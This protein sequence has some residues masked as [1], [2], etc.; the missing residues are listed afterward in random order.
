[1]R[2]PF[3]SF[4]DE[5]ID[6]SID[7]TQYHKHASI[8]VC[9]ICMPFE[10]LFRILSLLLTFNVHVQQGYGSWLCL[11]YTLSIHTGFT[12]LCVLCV[13]VL[14]YRIHLSGC[15]QVL[16]EGRPNEK[17][18]GQRASSQHEREAQSFC[19]QW[20]LQQCHVQV[21]HSGVRTILHYTCC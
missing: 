20:I 13:C 21:L 4:S 15:K 8:C 3:I 14:C 10:F 18:S 17:G 5:G 2:L 9:T 19:V 12:A 7:Q 11:C 16:G 6:P 1:M